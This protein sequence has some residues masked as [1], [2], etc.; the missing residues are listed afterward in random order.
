MVET[1]SRTESAGAF[2][3]SEGSGNWANPPWDTRTPH[4]RRDLL[5]V[6]RARGSTSRRVHGLPALA[7]TDAGTSHLLLLLSL[8]AAVDERASSVRARPNWTDE[9]TQPRNTADRSLPAPPPV[10]F[11]EVRPA[12]F[13]KN[14]SWDQPPQIRDC[15]TE[16]LCAVLS[17]GLMHNGYTA[18]F[19]PVEVAESFAFDRSRCRMH[20]LAVDPRP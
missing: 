2:C 11:Y 3:P 5:G 18:P 12:D 17:C 9:V 13:A 19:L 16:A 6:H 20:S 14:G 7:G 10:L 1:L 8:C 15:G 4:C